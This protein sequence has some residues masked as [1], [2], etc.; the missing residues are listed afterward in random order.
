MNELIKVRLDTG[1]YLV[2]THDE[3]LALSAKNRVLSYDIIYI[4][5]I[6]I[7]SKL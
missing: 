3:F 7:D 6:T 2:V 5:D 4:D 1:K